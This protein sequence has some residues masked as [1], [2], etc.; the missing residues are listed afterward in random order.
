MAAGERGQ[1]RSLDAGWSR[2]GVPAVISWSSGPR[3]PDTLPVRAERENNESGGDRAGSGVMSRSCA[4]L[5]PAEGVGAQAQVT[6]RAR[7][8]LLGHLGVP[9]GPTGALAAPQGAARSMGGTRHAEVRSG[10]CLV[11][12]FLATRG[13][14]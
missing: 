1:F 14:C 3:T 4:D 6:V 12:D 11:A 2:L 7:V 9:E 8:R 10:V 5:V 13:R